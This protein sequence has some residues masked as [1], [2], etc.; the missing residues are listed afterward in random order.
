MNL[1]T[2]TKRRTKRVNTFWGAVATV[3]LVAGYVV[4][5]IAENANRPVSQAPGT[6]AW[7][8][9]LQPLARDGS[10]WKDLLD[11]LIK[12]EMPYGALA[13]SHRILSLFTEQDVKEKAFE[14]IV[15]LVDFGYPYPTLDYFVT[16]DLEL[17]SDSNFASSYYLYKALASTEQG[18]RKWADYYL[19]LV[20]K[21]ES[22]KYYFYE[23]L[24]AYRKSDFVTAEKFLNKILDLKPI[25]RRR[26][27][28]KKAARTLARIY[29]EEKQ[30]AKSYDI[31]DSFLLQ[32]NPIEPN[33]WLEAAWDLYYL[34]K[35]DLALGLLSNL[36]SKAGGNM[37]NL[38]KYELRALIYQALC[39]NKY[40]ERLYNSFENEFGSAVRAI[41]TGKTLTQIPKLN[42][43]YF[44]GNGPYYELIANLKFL[45]EEQRHLP[46]L[47]PRYR[48]LARYLYRTEIVILEKKYPVYAEDA[49]QKTA[50][51]LI[52]YSEKL[53]F[54]NFDTAKNNVSLERAN[55]GE[56][57]SAGSNRA[58]P[59]VAPEEN[60]KIQWVQK[61]DFWR[62]ERDHYR[63]IV[64]NQCL[65]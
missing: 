62:D 49:S 9:A 5:A 34:K 24:E 57:K 23:S 63:A 60:F 38:E 42:H 44:V 64:D 10:L 11:E 7:V 14:T 22:E 31:Y 43:I 51:N 8:G 65:N 41:K 16:G 40:T 27:L 12:N 50:D 53:R 18:M 56:P 36:E 2:Y 55:P 54:I 4:P 6:T 3:V 17:A 48:E 46:N 15:E 26:S 47:P 45:K 21:E 19:G 52:S 1:S 58:S 25:P 13:A 20:N 39:Q 29:F 37:I 32:L 61:G 30:Y 28:I 59:E 33:D 35:Y